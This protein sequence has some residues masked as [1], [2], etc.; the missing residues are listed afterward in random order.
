MR[1]ALQIFLAALLA[2]H[3][4][5]LRAQMV[6]YAPLT[7]DRSILR[8]EV[9]GKAG[10][11]YW[12]WTTVKKKLARRQAGKGYGYGEEQRFEI[13][14]DRMRPVTTI[15]PR[16]DPDTAL[17]QYL[18]AGA[19]SFDQ[20]VLLPGRG[21]T[22]LFLDR[23]EPQGRALDEGRTIA[24]FP[25]HASGNNFLLLRSADQTKILALGFEP[26]PASPPRM[27]AI[28]FDQDWKILSNR[29]Y[30]HPSITQPIL[31]DDATS[32][33]IEDFDKSPVKLADNGQW[34]MTVPSSEDDNYVLFHFCGDDNSFSCKEISLPEAAR[35][36][37]VALSVDNKKGEII[38]G[39][40][41]RF[42][43]VAHKHV[44]TVH[45]S[46]ER[47]QFDFDSSYRFSTLLPGEV[48][49]KNLVKENFIAVPGEGFMLLKEYGR[50]FFGWG[51]DEGV[52]GSQLELEDF[53]FNTQNRNA[54]IRAPL[55]ED[56]Y[57][58]YGF[59]AGLGE[60]HGRGDLGLFY[61]PAVRSDSAW[62]GLMRKEQI[63]EF[64]APDLSYLVVPVK[65]KLFFLYNSSFR[66]G[67][68]GAST[69]IDHQGKPLSGEGVLF[70]Q[71]RN[72]LRFQQSRQISA[73]E[74]A[75]P[76]GNYQPEGF[77]IIRF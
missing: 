43:S 24:S 56:G 63:T 45:Y 50:S 36:E 77:A 75:V 33:P 74:V 31:Q 60:E 8:A 2:L 34:L 59:L 51:I 44:R 48:R 26:R 20:L 64:N 38:V 73:N 32:Y 58:R 30:E 65:D 9:A 14:D 28:L 68:H 10:D 5:P 76:Y 72:S 49:N 22:F 62:S 54:G 27:Y 18:I 67:N 12:V 53:I 6:L 39:I 3:T 15:S 21:K 19:A 71:I 42:R 16:V 55:L 69:I 57:A 37:D 4:R 35:M 46:M 40:L 66:N 17:K 47:Q 29:V 13:C 52:S 25:F 7:N 1:R 70:W 11:Y 61:F 41:S 23:Y